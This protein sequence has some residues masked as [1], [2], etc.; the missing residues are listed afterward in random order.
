[1]NKLVSQSIEFPMAIINN[2]HIEQLKSKANK[3]AKRA[4]DQHINLAVT[5]LSR[6]GKT[7]FITS[8]VNQLVAESS[9]SDMSY[10]KA[11]NHGRFIAAKRVPQKDLH[12]PRFDYE[13]AMGALSQTP[14]AWPEPTKGITQ[15]R[16]SVKFEPDSSILKYATDTATL[17]IDITDY[18]GEWLLD[19]PMLN[20]TYEEWSE[21]MQVLL[22]SSPRHEFAKSF[23]E[24]VKQLDPFAPTDENAL[25]ELASEYTAL[26]HI[27]R[28]KLGLSLIQPGRFILPGELENAPILQFVPFI[29]FSDI[30]FERYQKSN[31]ETMIGMMRARF[32]EYKERVVKQF[33]KKHFA[34][35]DRQVI[36]ADCL[37][38]LNQGVDSFKDLQQ[39]LALISQSFSYGKSNFLSRLF[40]P[41]IDKLL[42]VATKSDHTTPEQHSNL[43][44]LL[45]QLVQPIRQQ[46]SFENIQIDTLAIASIK[47]TKA[48]KSSYRGEDISVIQGCKLADNSTITLFPGEVPAELPNENYWQKNHFNFIAFSPLHSASEVKALPHLRMDQVLEFLIGDKM[49]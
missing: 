46:V 44:S 48:G 17:N 31:D 5:G 37:T 9:Q 1:M 13:S 43:V 4:L 42:F 27:F 2:E 21:A 20:Q 7:A 12:V 14:P 28:E 11:I 47:A 34:H 49:S 23:I 16:L 32:L 3:L 36:L 24:K 39:T 22:E 30:A 26:L 35:F 15:L 6:S 29:N 25:A 8:F 10:F 40:S 19:L 38:P 33:Y 41:K 45:N 18:P